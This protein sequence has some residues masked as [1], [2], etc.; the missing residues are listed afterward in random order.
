ME[1]VGIFYVYFVHITTICY[2]LWP[3]CGYLVYFSVL[4]CCSKKNLAAL[5]LSTTV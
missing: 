4:V 2:I 5:K 3:F 1:D